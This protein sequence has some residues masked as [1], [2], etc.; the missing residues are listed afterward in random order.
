M[1]NIKNKPLVTIC[2]PV[3][4]GEKFILDAL[5]SIAGQSY[6][7]FECHIINNA[8][9]DRTSELVKEY[10]KN[11]DRFEL[12]D[13][14]EFVDLVSNWNRTV[15]HISKEAKYFK[16]VQADD[17]LLPDSI[18]THVDLMEKYPDAGIASSYRIVG[19]YVYGTGIDFLEGEIHDGKQMLLKHL[20]GQAEITGSITQLFFRVSTLKQVPGYPEIF[21]PENF[22]VDTRLAFEMFLISDLAFAFRVLSYTRRHEQAAT[23]TKVELLNTYIQARE[24]NLFRFKEYFSELEGNYSKVRRSYAYFL[25]K[26][27]LKN[28][29]KSIDWHRKHLKRKITFSE[30][31]SGILREN[32]LGSRLDRMFG[33]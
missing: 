18:V 21:N 8:S 4:N 29:R 23:I 20:K 13:H 32:R 16:V 22:H 6:V 12:H 3:Y 28:N 25:F 14:K 24:T 19:N 2:I 10:I 15:E 11:D 26:S 27:R 5:G 1:D 17:I 31:L 7:N 30:Y 9:T 33:N